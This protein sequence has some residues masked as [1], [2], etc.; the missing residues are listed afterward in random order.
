MFLDFSDQKDL[1][2]CEKGQK[3]YFSFMRNDQLLFKSN[4]IIVLHWGY[5]GTECPVLNAI[6]L[7]WLENST[8]HWSLISQSFNNRLTVS[9][10]SHGDTSFILW[11]QLFCFSLDCTSVI[12][13]YSFIRLFLRRSGCRYI[14]LGLMQLCLI[15]N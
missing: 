2:Y 1:V 3:F 13:F 11:L 5:E 10:N 14:H 6:K 7:S 12:V 8:N 15:I 9:V 4:P